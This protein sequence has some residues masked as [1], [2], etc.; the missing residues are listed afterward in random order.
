MDWETYFNECLP[1][2]IDKI[3]ETVVG[4]HNYPLELPT[5]AVAYV[6]QL[7]M[8]HDTATYAFYSLTSR[9]KE[10]KQRHLYRLHI[11]VLLW[12][13][14]GSANELFESMS[15]KVQVD[16]IPLTATD[17]TL[18]LNQAQWLAK[19]T[20]KVLLEFADTELLEEIWQVMAATQDAEYYMV[21]KVREGIWG[22]RAF[23]WLD[24][25]HDEVRDKLQPLE[26]VAAAS[27]GQDGCGEDRMI[28]YSRC[29]LM[30]LKHAVEVSALT[31]EVKQ[32]LVGSDIQTA[33]GQ[34]ES[35][36]R[37]HRPLVRFDPQ[38]S[39]AMSQD[40][41]DAHGHSPIRLDPH[42]LL[43]FF[44]EFKKQASL[45]WAD[46]QAHSKHATG[47][48]GP[49]KKPR[50]KIKSSRK[51]AAKRKQYKHYW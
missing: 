51:G 34:I 12:F 17:N 1:Q 39:V 41:L 47:R 45:L 49:C 13:Y 23:A 38:Q 22:H 6:R 28:E 48:Y 35:Y 42:P 33:Y 30:Q 19:E 44:I 2:W 37:Y 24:R 8:Y 9:S 4:S 32:L 7:R 14:Q 15:Q 26:A 3:G 27:V 21:V 46:Y 36:Y 16:H 50:K 43:C 18:S 31:K 5:Q 10:Y 20:S 25:L 11:E 29:I 40:Q